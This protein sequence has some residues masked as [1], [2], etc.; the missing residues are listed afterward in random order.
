LCIGNGKDSWGPETQKKFQH[1]PLKKDLTPPR[2]HETSHD[3]LQNVTERITGSSIKVDNNLDET[4][5]IDGYSL[6]KIWEQ[7][8]Y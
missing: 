4:I 2:I 7:Q 8:L 5:D 6:Y 1:L 3:T